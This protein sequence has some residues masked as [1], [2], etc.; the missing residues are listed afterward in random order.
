MTVV[1]VWSWAVEEGL[2]LVGGGVEGCFVESGSE[3]CIDGGVERR[4]V[5]VVERGMGAADGRA[6]VVGKRG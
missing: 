2:R 4:G 6:D 1:V 5:D 3:V